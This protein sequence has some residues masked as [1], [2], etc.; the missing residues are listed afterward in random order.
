MKTITV[1]DYL[2]TMEDGTTRTV[3]IT[4]GK[5]SEVK[6]LEIM[7]IGSNGLYVEAKYLRTY[8]KE[9]KPEPLPEM[10]Y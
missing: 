1:S 3:T 8:K 7:H 4:G 2:V 5:L 6:A 10:Y 9:V